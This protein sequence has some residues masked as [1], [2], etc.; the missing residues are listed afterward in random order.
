MTRRSD[1]GLKASNRHLPGD[2][3]V[4]PEI[5]EWVDANNLPDMPLIFSSPGQIRELRISCSV[6]LQSV[7]KALGPLRVRLPV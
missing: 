3:L 4:I 7:A 1:A 2:G 6:N 5:P